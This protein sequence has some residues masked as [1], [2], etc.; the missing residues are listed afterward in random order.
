MTCNYIEIY[1]EEVYDLLAGGKSKKEKRKLII[2]EKDKVFY[3]ASNEFINL[4]DLTDK[5]ISNADDLI[6]AL[7]EGV[8][9]KIHAATN[10]N[11]YSSRSH[12]IFKVNLHYD[13]DDI[14]TFSIVDLAGC[15]RNSRTEANGK[16]LQQ[17]CKINYSLSVLGKCFD[18]LRF[19]SIYMSK[20]F[21]PF[22]ESKL[23]ML[24]Q[25]YFQGNQNITLIANIT[26]LREDYDE[27][28]RVLAYTSSIK[29]IKP[30]RSVIPQLR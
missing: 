2:K 17:A 12:T 10:L 26:S 8:G 18:A 25:E 27:T 28:I 21:V 1:N 3:L 7:N 5:P 24:F 22:R 4:L 15:E 23:T 19:N 16:E 20:R 14:I 29:E 13:D 6:E 11:N 30:I 9:K